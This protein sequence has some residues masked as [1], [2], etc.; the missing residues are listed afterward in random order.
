MRRADIEEPI[1]LVDVD[2]WRRP[3]CYPQSTFYPMSDGP[4]TQNHRITRPD[5]RLC[6]KCP[7]RSQAPFCPYTRRTISKRAEGT[8][9]RL[10][11]ILG[12]DRPS[13][14]ARL[15]LFP[16]GIHQSGLEPG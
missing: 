8:L 1:L 14:T 16:F 9:G 11:Y 5:F 13:Q 15:T 7:S 2:S 4:S 6:L 10:R 3:A 12:G